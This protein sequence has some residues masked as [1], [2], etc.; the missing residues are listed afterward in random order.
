MA[1]SNTSTNSI[2]ECDFFSCHRKANTILGW[3]PWLTQEDSIFLTTEWHARIQ[4]KIW[5]FL[6]T[7][8]F[9]IIFQTMIDGVK[10]TPLRQIFDERGKIMHMMSSHSPYLRYLVNLLHLVILEL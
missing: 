7:P 3:K 1:T 10:T 2:K 5:A 9:L 6:L 4:N 8:K